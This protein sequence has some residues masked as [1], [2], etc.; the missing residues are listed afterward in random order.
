[1]LSLLN[2]TNNEKTWVKYHGN[3]NQNRICTI[4]YLPSNILNILW[5]QIWQSKNPNDSI[6]NDGNEKNLDEYEKEWAEH[7]ENLWWVL[8]KH[9]K[10]APIWCPK[11]P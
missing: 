3:L 1:M 4:N 11:L 2:N 10:S 7:D 6:Q 9:D 5:F 8:I